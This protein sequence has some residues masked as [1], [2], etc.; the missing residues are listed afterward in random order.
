MV[1]SAGFAE[2]GQDGEQLQHDLVTAAGSMALIGPN[3]SGVLNFVSGA[4]LY[5]FQHGSEQVSRGIAFVTQ[6]GMLGNTLT[7]N[8]RSLPIAYVISA[9]NQ[10]VCSIEE[11]IESLND[12][13][14]VSAI[15]LYIE[16]LTD[17]GRFRRLYAS[18]ERGVPVVAMKAGTSSIGANW[19]DA[20]RS[21]AG[22][23][24][25]YRPSV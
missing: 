1:Y 20:H 21:L 11:I 23:D 5:G 25:L 15:A 14:A 16:G 7:L 9:G 17:I 2:L 4:H 3:S 13:A 19:P 12:N 10:A 8:D 22:A 6:S 24:A 18:V